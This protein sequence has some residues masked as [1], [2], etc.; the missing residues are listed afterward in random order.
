VVVEVV[1]LILPVVQEAQVQVVVDQEEMQV[2]QLIL[3]E[4]LILVEELEDHLL[5]HLNQVDQ[6]LLQLDI[7][8]KLDEQ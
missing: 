2:V 4:Q 3:M 5:N 7:N 1:R 6:D 8:S